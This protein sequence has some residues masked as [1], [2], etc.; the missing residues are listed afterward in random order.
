MR[1]LPALHF[2]TEVSAWGSKQVLQM[3]STLPR[4]LGGTLFPYRSTMILTLTSLGP[5][6]SIPELSISSF[7][8]TTAENTVTHQVG[9]A[10]Q[11]L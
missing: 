10:F 8:I 5:T 7:V 4:I 2:E 11:P 1:F 3:M 6:Q 9:L